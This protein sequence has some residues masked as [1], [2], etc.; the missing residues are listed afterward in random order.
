MITDNVEKIHNCPVCN[1]GLGDFYLVHKDELHRWLKVVSLIQEEV[2]IL[3][4]G[5]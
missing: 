5:K 2:K 1:S 3:M 4:G